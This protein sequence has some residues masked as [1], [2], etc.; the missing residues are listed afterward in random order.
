M[1]LPIWKGNGKAI[2]SSVLMGSKREGNFSFIFVLGNGKGM[3][4]ILELCQSGKK[5]GR[6]LRAL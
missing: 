3:E 2:L 6:N 1:V 4:G 5:M